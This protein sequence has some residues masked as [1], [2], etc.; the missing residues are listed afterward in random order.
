MRNSTFLRVK[1][2]RKFLSLKVP[3]QSPLV[4]VAKVVWGELK[5]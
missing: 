2:D 4:L 5:K 3:R 1:T